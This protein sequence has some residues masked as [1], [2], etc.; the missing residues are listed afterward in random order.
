MGIEALKQ[1]LAEG[2]ITKEQFEAEL[3]KLL[4]AGTITREDY[5]KAI[6]E[7]AGEGGRGNNNEGGSNGLT[8]EEV[9]KLIQ[10]ET[11]KVRTEYSK[12]LKA[13]QEELEK[14]KT[15]KMTAEERA[16]YE[17]EKLEQELREREQKLLE[18]EVKLHT[19]DKLRELNLPLEFRD[20]LAG[21]DIETTE[22]RIKTFAEQWQKA[23][24]AAVDAKFKE[25]GDNPAKGKGGQAFKNPWSKEHWNLTEQGRI[26][27][28]DPERAR[29]L[30]AAAGVKL[31][32]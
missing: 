26:F 29:Q 30:A 2:K 18:R 28:E 13:A 15:E 23:L 19:V 24:K 14:L 17:Q 3:K 16:K 31:N 8:L 20:I 21:P 5:E 32:F 4:D 25:H 12:K 11:D 6:T 9:K 10:S 1:Q 22:E 27:R 7:I